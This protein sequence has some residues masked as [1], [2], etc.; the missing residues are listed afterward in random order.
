MIRGVIFDLDGV[1]VS[2]D[3]LH[4][5]S[6]RKLAEEEGIPFDPTINHRL[7]GVS[8]MRSLDILLERSV[9]SHDAAQKQAMADRKNATFVTLLGDLTPSDILPGAAAC[10][11]T[12]KGRHIRIAVASSSRNA[13]RILQR[14]GLAAAFDAVV[15]GNDITESKPDP[16][17]FHKAARLLGLPAAE[18]LVIEDAPAGIEA[19]RQA[20]MHV[21]GIGGPDVLPGVA[22]IATGLDQVTVEEL[23]GA[24]GS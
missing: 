10:I 14:L 9:R 12:L 18:C 19:A 13:R 23:L 6:W 21:F 5:Q 15:D 11:E 24:A 3:A 17:V 22:N 4:Y 8:R 1:L 20:G 16:E 7:R 2:T